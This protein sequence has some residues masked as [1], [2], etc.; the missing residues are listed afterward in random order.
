MNTQAKQRMVGGLVLL[1]LLAI[2]LPIFFGNPNPGTQNVQLSSKTAAP[3]A[4]PRVELQLPPMPSKVVAVKRPAPVKLPVI[5]TVSPKPAVHPHSS[6]PTLIKKVKAPVK[7]LA[8]G[9]ES[10]AWVVQLASFSSQDNADRLIKRLRAA[11]YDA[12]TRSRHAAAGKTLIQVFVGPE[13]KRARVDALLLQLK[14]KYRLSGVVK[15]YAV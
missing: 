12:Y 2:F 7:A 9:A 5:A 8:V 14:E 4:S 10:T 1:A 13:I 6:K 15:R 11:G 3:P